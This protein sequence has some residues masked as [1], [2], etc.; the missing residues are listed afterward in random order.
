M[1]PKTTDGP[2]YSEETATAL[3]EDPA[4]FTFMDQTDGDIAEKTLIFGDGETYSTSD[5]QN[6]FVTHS[7]AIPGDY[8][9]TLILVYTILLPKSIFTRNRNSIMSL[10]TPQYLTIS[11][12]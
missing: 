5:P 7:Y 3:A 12:K 8:E 9:P 10:P 1:L 2:T 11:M 4:V 6:H